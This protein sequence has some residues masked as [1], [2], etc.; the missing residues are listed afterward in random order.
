MV[1]QKDRSGNKKSSTLPI[2]EANVLSFKNVFPKK[3]KLS[4]QPVLAWNYTCGI[5]DGAGCQQ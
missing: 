2:K 3:Y 5:C 1:Q 4:K